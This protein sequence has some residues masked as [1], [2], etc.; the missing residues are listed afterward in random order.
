MPVRPAPRLH[1]HPHRQF[2]RLSPKAARLRRLRRGLPRFPCQRHTRT[3][4]SRRSKT[5]FRKLR[6]QAR[7]LRKQRC[8]LRRMILPAP[9]PSLLKIEKL[10]SNAMRPKR[11]LPPR[12]RRLS[13]KPPC[14]SVMPQGARRG[15]LQVRRR[16]PL[17][18]KSLRL[19]VLLVL[20]HRHPLRQE[21]GPMRSHRPKRVRKQAR[22]Q[23]LP[24]VRRAH[25]HPASAQRPISPP[26]I[27]RRP[28]QCRLR[29]RAI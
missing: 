19:R 7:R 29:R 12:S 4:S 8:V 9:P 28:T 13:R 23:T 18:S 1:P 17:R 11:V 27:R 21:H 15:R 26:R 24:A 22:N 6:N 25:R 2:R 10:R 16:K 20:A 5:R 14:I 3:R